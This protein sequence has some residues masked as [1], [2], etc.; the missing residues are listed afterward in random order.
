MHSTVFRCVF[1]CVYILN[2]ILFLFTLMRAKNNLT[3]LVYINA[4]IPLFG[5]ETKV[6]D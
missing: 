2:G 4:F 3:N 1:T 6:L 5:I